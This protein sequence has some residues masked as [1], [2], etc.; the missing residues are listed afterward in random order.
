MPAWIALKLLP[1]FELNMPRGRT[2]ME[3]VRRRSCEKL[4]EICFA[5]MQ[6]LDIENGVA[7]DV[8][9]LGILESYNVKLCMLSSAAEAAEQVS[10]AFAFY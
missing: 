9:G 7:A 10:R 5:I 8:T 4:L 3:L 1:I 6:F 2:V